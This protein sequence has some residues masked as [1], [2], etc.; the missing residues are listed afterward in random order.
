MS[1]L[2]V[3][4]PQSAQPKRRHFK[5]QGAS[6]D[7]TEGNKG[8]PPAVIYR[9]KKKARARSGT[10]EPLEPD[11]ANVSGGGILFFELASRIGIRIS[12]PLNVALLGHRGRGGGLRT[13]NHAH[14]HTHTHATRTGVDHEGSGPFWIKGF[15]ATSPCAVERPQFLVLVFF[16]FG[17]RGERLTPE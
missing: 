7:K 1:R 5:P 17:S 9:R 15:E 10:R 2:P 3:Q 16:F 8:L 13:K 11:I 6:S 14:T 4:C 12:R